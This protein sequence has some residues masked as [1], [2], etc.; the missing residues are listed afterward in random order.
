MKK[1]KAT[2]K[3]L[4]EYLDQISLRKE[5][6]QR[7]IYDLSQVFSDYV[8]MRKKGDKLNTFMRKKHGQDG[9]GSNA[10]IPTRWSVFYKSFRDNY[11]KLK[12]KL[13]S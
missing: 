8:E 13:V 5:N 12:K 3:E 4:I 2:Y 11:L 1:K 6:N 9:L 7:S 10:G